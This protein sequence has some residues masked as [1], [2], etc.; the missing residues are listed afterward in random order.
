MRKAIL[1][2]LVGGIL[3]PLGTGCSTGMSPST[4]S[5]VPAGVSGSE[6]R[7]D[8]AS[9]GILEFPSASSDD[10]WR[11]LPG[12]FQTLGIPADILD[13]ANRVYGNQ[14]VTAQRVADK[15][16]RDLFRCGSGGGLASVQYRIQF[17]IMA[18]P[19]PRRSGGSELRLET[20]A[21]GRAVSASASGTT[22]CVSTGLLE[23]RFREVIEA[24]LGGNAS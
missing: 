10:L 1:F 18:Q 12:A 19:F 2:F 6:V 11:V 4:L 22:Q 13:A 14:R 24:A 3:L 15:P 5:G 9:A 21:T 23:M 17:G 16:L 7:V 20:A 8:P